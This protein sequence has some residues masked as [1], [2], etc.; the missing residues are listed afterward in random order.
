MRRVARKDVA[1]LTGDAGPYNST[2]TT[3]GIASTTATIIAASL[4]YTDI[5]NL[6]RDQV[7]PKIA[8]AKLGSLA[9]G[10]RLATQ[11]M[12]VAGSAARRS[13]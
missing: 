2:F 9:E 7:D 4:G 8:W 5:T 13:S 12:F 3:N 10:A 6:G 11:A 1:H